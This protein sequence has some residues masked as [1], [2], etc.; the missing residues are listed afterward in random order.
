MP[1]ARSN[2]A[3]LARCPAGPFMGQGVVF[4]NEKHIWQRT[5]SSLVAELDATT[6]GGQ[7]K[8]EDRGQARC[9]CDGSRE[10]DK[11]CQRAPEEDT[12]GQDFR[13]THAEIFSP[14]HPHQPDNRPVG[15]NADSYGRRLPMGGRGEHRPAPDA[16][17]ALPAPTLT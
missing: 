7:Q 14:T 1:Q 2:A 6:A 3:A 12:S 11:G 8:N 17:G 15:G 4:R 5:T 10:H 13:R 9:S 16:D